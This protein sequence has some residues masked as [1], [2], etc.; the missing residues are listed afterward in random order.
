MGNKIFIYLKKGK[1]RVGNGFIVIHTKC[2]SKCC[3]QVWYRV[4]IVNQ[5]FMTV[6]NKLCAQ[7]F[8]YQFRIF[9]LNEYSFLTQNSEIIFL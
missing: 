8:L 9:R 2:V 7:K 6:G 5:P 3:A 1:R 4:P